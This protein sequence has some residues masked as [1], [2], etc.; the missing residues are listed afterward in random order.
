M[1]RKRN[2]PIKSTP[3]KPATLEQGDESESEKVTLETAAK[4]LAG[5]LREYEDAAYRAN[6]SN[7]YP[8]FEG[9]AQKIEVARRLVQDG[10]IAYALG[11]CLVEHMRF[12]GT[13]IHRNDFQKYVGFAA[14]DIE[15]FSETEETGSRTLETT[16]VCFTFNT[17]RYRFVFEDRG[18]SSIPGDHD[19][20]GTVEFFAGS[21]RVAKF[22]VFEPLEGEFSHWRFRDVLALKVGNWMKDVIDI[23]SQIEARHQNELYDNY[24]DRVRSVAEQ[25]DLTPDSGVQECVDKD[26]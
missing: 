11:R 7:P 25:I 15:A 26:S 6:C 12:W 19:R 4:E 3:E 1:F 10:R 22:E 5:S 8:D 17:T 20:D 24:Y 16:T 18:W 14:T 21:D 23:A 13:W 2:L 9:D